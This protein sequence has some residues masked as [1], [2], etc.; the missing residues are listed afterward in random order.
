MIFDHIDW[1]DANIVHATRH[2]ISVDEIEQVIANANQWRPNSAGRTG[3]FLIRD[4]ADAGRLIV[5]IV[6]YDEIRDSVR[7]IAAW[8]EDT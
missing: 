7:P 3:D 2:G 4:Y 5:L 6:A 8:E 1:D